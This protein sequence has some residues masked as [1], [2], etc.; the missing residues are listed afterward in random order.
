MPLIRCVRVCAQPSRTASW[1]AV[2]GPG[3]HIAEMVSMFGRVH[4]STQCGDGVPGNFAGSGNDRDEGFETD[5]TV[6]M[7]GGCIHSTVPCG[8]GRSRR[9]TETA[10]LTALNAMNSIRL[11]HLVNI[12]YLPRVAS[13]GPPLQTDL[14]AST[15]PVGAIWQSADRQPQ[16]WSSLTWAKSDDIPRFQ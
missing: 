8:E 12:S 6:E 4:A 13:V 10:P 7:R 16:H 15:P 1:P 14:T 11:P 2:E 9:N 3:Q 5:A